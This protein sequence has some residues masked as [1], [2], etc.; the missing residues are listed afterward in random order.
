MVTKPGGQKVSIWNATA[1]KRVPVLDALDVNAPFRGKAAALARLERS[2][3]KSKN[4]VRA[5]ATKVHVASIRK[6]VK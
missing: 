4:V 1:S 5:F 3:A 2:R 6:P